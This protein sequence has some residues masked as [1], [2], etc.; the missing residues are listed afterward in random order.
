MP[1][2]QCG[3][4]ICKHNGEEGCCNNPDEVKLVPVKIGKREY[5]TCESYE[6]GE[7]EE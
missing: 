5:L 1:K 2:I 7:G 3:W 6:D 4:D